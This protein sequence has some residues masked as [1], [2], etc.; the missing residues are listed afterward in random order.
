MSDNGCG[1][2]SANPP[3]KEGHHSVGLD[4]IRE[5]L[6]YLGGTMEIESAIGAGTQVRIII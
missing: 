4:N 6:K 3:K 2:D 5:R 1:F